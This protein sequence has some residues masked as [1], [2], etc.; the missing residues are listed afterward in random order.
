MIR[1]RAARAIGY[2][3]GYGVLSLIASIALLPLVFN[4]VGA[5]PYGA[6]IFIITLVQYFYYADFGV[7]SAVV[8]FSARARGGDES[9]SLD[10]LTSTALAWSVI[11]AIVCIPIYVLAARAYLSKETVSAVIPD[12]SSSALVLLSAIA[13]AVIVL[14]P[15]NAVLVGVGGFVAERKLQFVGLFVR[16]GGTIVACLGFNSL[17][18]VAFAEVL[19]LILP[20]AGAAILVLW[21]KIVTVRVSAVSVTTWREMTSYSLRSVASTLASLAAIQGGTI[22]AG[23]VG[24]PASVSYYNAALRVYS[25]IRNVGQWCTAPF[26]TALSRSYVN[27]VEKANAVVRSATFGTLMLVSFAAVAVYLVSYPLMELWLG[28]DVPVTEVANTVNIL[29]IGLVIFSLHG[30]LSMASAAA[31]RPGLFFP[32]QLAWALTGSAIGFLLGREIG[33]SGVAWGMV[34]PLIIIEPLYFYVAVRNLEVDLGQ[35]WR[36]CLLPVASIV[37]VSGTGGVLV[38]ALAVAELRPTSLVGPAAAALFAMGAT[39]L[40][41]S[42]IFHRYLPWGEFRDAMNVEV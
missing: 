34:I 31:G 30:P 23:L 10:E 2:S 12:N 37:G 13:V 42:V 17:V 6:W 28:S 15:F 24:T 19:A 35:W 1:A 22:V 32:L 25:G 5:G 9:K 41:V 16:A 7:G 39:A 27:S 26:Q 18:G 38:Q 20:T 33:I 36:R 29:L 4:S 14:R 40:A 21:K 8:H 3:T 11:A